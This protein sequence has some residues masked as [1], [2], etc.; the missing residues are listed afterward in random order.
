MVL[1]MLSICRLCINALELQIF[2]EKHLQNFC[3]PDF[4]STVSAE[5]SD[6]L[7]SN[8]FKIEL[9]AQTLTKM[10]RQGTDGEC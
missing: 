10:A 2:T 4:R 6:F 3:P 1:S 8:T 7:V 9:I 5:N